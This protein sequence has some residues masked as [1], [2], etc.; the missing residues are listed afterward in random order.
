[1]IFSSVNAIVKLE[2]IMTRGGGNRHYGQDRVAR[3]AIG[4]CFRQPAP[5]CTI[6]LLPRAETQ[7]A[8]SGKKQ[9]GGGNQRRGLVAPRSGGESI[10]QIRQNSEQQN[11][12]QT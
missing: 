5:E 1:M 7:D 11:Q 3:V 9:R 2:G 12:Q 8:T 4:D 10:P 6:S